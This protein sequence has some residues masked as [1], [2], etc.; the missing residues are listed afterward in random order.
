WNGRM[1]DILI[2]VIAGIAVALYAV[3]LY[4]VTARAVTERRRELGVRLALG[5]SREQLAWLT[6]RRALWQVF[7][8]LLLGVGLT[9][10]WESVSFSE[11]GL[12]TLRGLGTATCL[13]LLVAAVASWAPLRR[14]ARLDPVVTLRDE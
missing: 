1:S 9:V 12:N 8:G 13:L 3:G 6:A 4:A 14:V 10:M 2:S 5:A 7:L 11:A